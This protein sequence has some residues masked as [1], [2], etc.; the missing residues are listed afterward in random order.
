MKKEKTYYIYEVPGKKIGCTTNPKHRI[1][2]E[3]HLVDYIILHEYKC[4]YIASFMERFLQEQKGYKVDRQ[5]YYQTV[6]NR[7][8]FNQKEG[9]QSEL[10]ARVKNRPTWKDAPGASR[11]GRLSFWTNQREKALTLTR[12][13]QVLATKAAAVSPNRSSL[14]AYSCS[15]CGKQIMGAA[16]AGRHAKSKGHTVTRLK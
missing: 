12:E 16:P 8:K 2:T 14:I 4:I 9:L 1:E 13:A 15:T 7:F 5:P 3:Q 11:K 10:S 6:A